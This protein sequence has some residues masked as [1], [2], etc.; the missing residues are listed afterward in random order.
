VTWSLTGAVAVNVKAAM[1]KA[2]PTGDTLEVLD[3]NG[4]VIDHDNI[5]FCVSSSNSS[6]QFSARYWLPI[7]IN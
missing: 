6:Y 7:V 3:K 5:T 1:P 4:N 2:L